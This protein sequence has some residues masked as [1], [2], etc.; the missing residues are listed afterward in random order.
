MHAWWYIAPGSRLTAHGQ[1]R[2]RGL[3]R[4]GFPVIEP[5]SMA[6]DPA[7]L[8]WPCTMSLEPSAM[9]HQACIKHLSSITNHL[10][11]QN[12]TIELSEITTW[13]APDLQILHFEKRFVAIEVQW[14]IWQVSLGIDWLRRLYTTWSSKLF[15][16]TSN[17]TSYFSWT[18]I[19]SPQ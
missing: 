17:G 5:G 9:H 2:A 16:I 19:I 4:S 8:Y 7:P 13:P 3:P 12:S 11:S 14:L 6:R 1:G 15:D 18:P 10:L